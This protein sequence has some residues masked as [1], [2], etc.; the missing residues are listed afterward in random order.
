MLDYCLHYF[1]GI[2]RKVNFG[3]ISHIPYYLQ[4]A[5]STKSSAA[6]EQYKLK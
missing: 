3:Q 6:N 5:L 1:L 2:E 4:I